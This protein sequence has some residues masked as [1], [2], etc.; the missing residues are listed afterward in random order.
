[1]SCVFDSTRIE[2]VPSQ[3]APTAIVPTSDRAIG[4]LCVMLFKS[5]FVM[6][7]TE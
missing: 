4:V 7:I 5:G 1:M 6:A 2:T 3:N